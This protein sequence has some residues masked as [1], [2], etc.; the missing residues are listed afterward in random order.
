[1]SHVLGLELMTE[2]GQIFARLQEFDIFGGRPT[3][4]G[5][6]FTFT[7]VIRGTEFAT[8]TE[9]ALANVQI[10]LSV[11]LE[12][13]QALFIGE[14]RERVSSPYR[15]SI[16]EQSFQRKIDITHDAYWKLVDFTHHRD[17]ELNF[18]VT[19]S[20][21]GKTSKGLETF[22]LHGERRGKIPHSEWLKTLSTGEFDRFEIITL[23]TSLPPLGKH[24]DKYDSAFKR[25]REA[26][27]NFNHGD[28][29][30]VG[31]KCRAAW[32]VLKTLIPTEQ[33]NQAI[34]LLLGSVTGDP[35]R[36]EFAAAVVKGVHDI[37]N[38]ATHLEG[39]SSAHTEPVDLQRE[40]ALLCLHW[41]SATISYVAAV[42]Q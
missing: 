35:R 9:L 40:D 14:L 42:Y 12:N 23:R 27:D 20:G 25:L 5:V 36:K 28:W 30:S 6:E 24:K 10:E 3:L 37:L 15:V 4:A 38:K 26:Q 29:N 13:D 16:H 39:D 22:I 18:N 17:L 21:T 2:G 19:A 11:F 41:T 7:F 1:M 8:N 33:K 31:S 32:L 34:E